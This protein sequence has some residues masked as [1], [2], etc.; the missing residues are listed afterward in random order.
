MYGSQWVTVSGDLKAHCLVALGLCPTMD[1]HPQ[2]S[3]LFLNFCPLEEYC[4]QFD[5]SIQHQQPVSSRH[6]WPCSPTSSH[7]DI[8]IYIFFQTTCG[9]IAFDLRRKRPQWK[10][11]YTER[12]AVWNALYS[13]IS[14]VKLAHRTDSK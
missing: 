7:P 11:S 1:P 12:H 8:Y 9:K 14:C 2:T 13:R 6:I 10:I 5:L 3:P 4:P